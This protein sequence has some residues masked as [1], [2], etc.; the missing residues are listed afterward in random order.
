MHV[1]VH[2]HVRMRACAPHVHVDTTHGALG[3]NRVDEDV[4]CV[5]CVFEFV[6]EFCDFFVWKK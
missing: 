5:F 3:C 6:A 1:H 4:G 2:V